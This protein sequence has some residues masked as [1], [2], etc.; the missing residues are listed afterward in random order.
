MGLLAFAALV[1]VALAIAVSVGCPGGGCPDDPPVSADGGHFADLL[2]DKKATPRRHRALKAPAEKPKPRAHSPKPR[3]HTPA[4]DPEPAAPAPVAE[5]EP[6]PAADPQPA[7]P[8]PAAD[9]EPATPAPLDV[10][11]AA[12]YVR[13]F[14]ADL[15]ER[16]F[17]A[18]WPRL[19]A[20]LRS[21]H[22]SFT[23]WERGFATTVSQSISDVFAAQ[24]GPDSAK[25]TLTL[26]AV[27]RTECNLEV[28]RRFAVIWRLEQRGG[29]WR[30]VHAEAEALGPGAPC[31]VRL[32]SS[33]D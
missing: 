14:Y 7:T 26:T 16:R 19:A 24:L 25:V 4:V 12:D 8:A 3:T 5:P 27:D 30:A 29:E 31:S 21:R 13:A 32:A 15:A 2:Q 1:T 28:T 17:R 10:A 9:P 18:A 33:K 6:A 22:G 23:A 11:G 20:D